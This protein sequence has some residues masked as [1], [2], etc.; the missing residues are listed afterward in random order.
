MGSVGHAPNEGQ[1][2]S[3]DPVWCPQPKVAYLPAIEPISIL[4]ACV[5]FTCNHSLCNKKEKISLWVYGKVSDRQQEA[6]IFWKESLEKKVLR[7]GKLRSL[8]AKRECAN[9]W[10]AKNVRNSRQTALKCNSS[11]ITASN[12]LT[13]TVEEEIKFTST[14]NMERRKRE[15]KEILENSVRENYGFGVLLTRTSFE[16]VFLFVN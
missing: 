3:D 4:S 1:T 7:A 15:G 10:H 13:E 11:S 8:A 5:S 9:R 2:Q 12:L 16:F 14:W 6:F